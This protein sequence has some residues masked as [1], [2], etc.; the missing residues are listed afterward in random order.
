LVKR[1]SPALARGA[2]K[3]NQGTYMAKNTL[4][5]EQRSI[6]K[7]NPAFAIIRKG[8]LAH[9]QWMSG[10]AAKF[11]LMLHLK[12][13]WFGPKRGWVEASF[14]DMARWCGWSTKTLSRTVEELEVQPYIE[15]E[16]AANQHEL[17]RIRI[18]KYDLDESTS[19]VDKSVQ[20]STV[21]VD[22]AVDCAVDSAA[23]KSVHSKPTSSQNTQDL[24]APKKLKEVKEEK[25]GNSDAVRRPF[26]AELHLINPSSKSAS[27]FKKNQNL[28]ARLAAKIQES[29]YS[30]SDWADDCEKRGYGSPVSDDERKA[31][32]A[33]QYKPNL[34]SP[35]L[36][37]DFINAVEDVWE[38]NREKGLLPG[39]LCSKI[40]DY[41]ESERKRGGGG[42]Y[43]PP[44]FVEH[45]NK[46]RA[47]ERL[48]E[49][50]SAKSVGVRA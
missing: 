50:Q 39:I 21:G 48:I 8:L 1:K 5:H 14:D 16:R 27:R 43:Y 24:Q 28:S 38:D 30:F 26:D 41:C 31:F 34:E 11:Y 20:S 35:L 3:L 49:Q 2:R 10:N 23:D 19:A 7:R 15:V 45:R 6:E 47:R 25:K 44:D 46:L 36:S 32:E 42:Y 9:L 4:A 29:G 37:M 18:L 17:T 33:T 40:I 12:A 13:C 22:S